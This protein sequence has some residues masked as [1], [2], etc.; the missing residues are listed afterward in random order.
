MR[1][2]QSAGR[3]HRHEGG[4]V[5]VQLDLE[6]ASAMGRCVEWFYRAL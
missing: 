5:E 6:I 4:S 1:A 3:C 2:Q